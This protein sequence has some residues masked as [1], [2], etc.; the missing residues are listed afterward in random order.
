MH[1][2]SHD[3]ALVALPLAQT[4]AT[5]V[6][7]FA[8]SCEPCKEKV[9]ALHARRTELEAAGGRIVLVAVLADGESTEEAQQASRSWG[10][11]APFLVDRGGV[12]RRECAVDSLP[13]TVVLDARG[14]VRWVASPTASAGEVV[15]AARAVAGPP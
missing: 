7:A 11:E 5:V 9:P 2:P 3:G 1:L 8:P 12:L 14:A 4:R 10:V 13:A 6:D 15:A